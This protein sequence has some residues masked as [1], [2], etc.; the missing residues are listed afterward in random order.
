[1]KSF[2]FASSARRFAPR[3]TGRVMAALLV[4]S[5][6]ALGACG[7]DEASSSGAGGGGGDPGDTPE[8]QALFAI[9]AD[10]AELQNET[11]F[12]QPFPSD[13]RKDGGKVITKGWPYGRAQLL[14]LYADSIDR[15]LDG[16]SPVAAGFLRF[17]APIDPATLPADPG[18]SVLEGSGVQLVDIDPASPTLGERHPIRVQFRA[19]EGVYIQPNTLAYIP[20]LGFPLLPK[21]RY[22]LVVTTAVK[23]A[24]GGRVGPSDALAAALAGGAAPGADVLGPAADALEAARIPSASIVH[25]AVFTTNDPAEELMATAAA[26]PSQIEA[27]TADPD[28]WTVL[29]EGSDYLELGGVYGPS[30]NYQ[31]G[32]IPFTQYGDGGNFVIGE[33]GAAE[34]QGTFDARFSLMVPRAA[35]CPMPAGGYPLVLYAHGTGGNY[36]SYARDSTGEAL[37]RKCMATMGVDQIFHGT[38]P[39]TPDNTASIELL[40][41]NFQNPDAARTNIRQSALDEVQRARI[42]GEGQL[43]VPAAVAEGGAAVRFDPNRIYFFG[44]SQGS[45][46]GPLFM[47][48]SDY[49]SGGVLSGASSYITVTLLEKTEPTPSVAGLVTGVFLGLKGDEPEE[50]DLFHP[51]LSLAQLIEDPV[52][53]ISYARLL[54]RDPILAPKSVLVTE[55][56]APDG[57]GDSYAPP[58]GCE[59]LAMGMGI[60]IQEPVVRFPPD[61]AWGGLERVTISASGLGGNLP[62]GTSGVLAQWAPPADSDGHFVIFDVPAA[63]GQA[64][65]FLRNLADGSDAPIPAP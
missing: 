28:A 39:G 43:E 38:R 17:S 46:N 54:A 41:F 62:K 23:G 59:A 64:A 50:V 56:I 25:L 24:A 37:A 32:T 19:E 1:M 34:V 9:P 16:F 40:F 27:P 35:S 5:T 13:L 44:H 14:Q 51:A 47:A 20:A 53:S 61:A 6:F 58:R 31:A 60:P 55:G 15:K 7:D 8:V 26:L 12:D 11:F 2:H 22:A 33:G 10:P 18:A 49:A 30:P 21:H 52:D 45:L 63:Q 48:A 42:V 57:K 3:F 65:Q 36:R 29:D 4:S